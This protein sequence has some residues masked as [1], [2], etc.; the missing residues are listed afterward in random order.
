VFPTKEAGDYFNNNVI[1]IKYELDIADPDGIMEKYSIRAYPTFIFVDG[2][3]KEYARFLGG[4]SDTKAFLE[5]TQ[6]AIKP[7]N[8]WAY[9]EAKLKSDP[10]YTMEHIKFLNDIYMQD[11]AKELLNKYFATRNVKENFSEE[12]LQLYNSLITDT[13]SPIVDYM[14]S[15]QK[16]VSEVMGEEKY[17]SFLTSKAT[18]QLSNRFMRL[19][20][21][22]PETV[23]DFEN[24]LKKMNA[25]PRFKSKY[26][27]F[28]A[29]NLNHIK[30]KNIDAIFDNSKKILPELNTAERSML[31]NLNSSAARILK[32]TVEQNVSTQRSIALYEIAVKCEKDPRYLE[33]YTRTLERLK[34]PQ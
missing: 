3:G 32:V 21:E 18:S 34:N 8:S 33:S 14:L 17:K 25:N 31:L 27:E 30:A 13:N 11:P 19:N 29:N 12:S 26:S 6:N 4:A 9:R 28:L 24:D 23:A 2:D 10:S 7:E 16:E 5:K 20:F 22:K 1:L 15:H